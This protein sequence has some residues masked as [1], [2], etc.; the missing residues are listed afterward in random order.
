MFNNSDSF[1][2]SGGTFSVIYGNQL[3][4][5]T[6]SPQI[7][8]CFRTGEKWKEDIYRE[9]ERIST[10]NIKLIEAIAETKVY[11]YEAPIAN[12]WGSD[13]TVR[14]K[15]VVQWACIVIGTQETRP[16]LSIRYTG[17]DAKKASFSQPF[18][19]LEI[20]ADIES[21]SI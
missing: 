12:M 7:R 15:R 20:L 1:S 3:N 14:A 2:I 8:H 17:R 10:G 21:N 13:S 16:S 19:L 18:V 5:C 6:H 11:Q 4:H 9:Y